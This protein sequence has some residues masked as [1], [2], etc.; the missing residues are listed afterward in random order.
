MSF[1]TNAAASCTELAKLSGL[2]RDV[3]GDGAAL[4]FSFEVLLRKRPGNVDGFFSS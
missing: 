2:E 3:G 1:S 4:T